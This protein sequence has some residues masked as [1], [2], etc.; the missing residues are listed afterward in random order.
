[1]L[2]QGV[3]RSVKILNNMAKETQTSEKVNHEPRP[4]TNE[5]MSPEN[6]WERSFPDGGNIMCKGPV[7]R[8]CMTW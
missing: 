1:M 5:K 2:E 3:R 8:A 6:S 7:V 4:K